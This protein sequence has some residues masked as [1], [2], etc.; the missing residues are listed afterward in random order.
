MPRPV[1]RKGERKKSK[2]DGK[3]N[4]FR[5]MAEVG[6]KEKGKRGSAKIAGEKK[7]RT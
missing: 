2:A 6:G 1:G 4:S 7:E 5:D 3:S